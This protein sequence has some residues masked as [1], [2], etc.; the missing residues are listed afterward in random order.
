MACQCLCKSPL[1]HPPECPDPAGKLAC[2]GDVGHD[3]S[4]AKVTREVPSSLY[5]PLYAGRRMAG[6]REGHARV[7]QCPLPFLGG[8]GVVPGSFHEQLPQVRVARL[9]DAASR[10]ALAAGMLG[11]HE[12]KPRGKRA[13]R[14]EAGEDARLNRDGKCRHGL[15][16][17][18]AA[19]RLDPACPSGTTCMLGDPLL[20]CLLLRL[21]VADLRYVEVQGLVRRGLGKLDPPDPLPVRL[22]PRPPALALGRALVPDVSPSDQEM[23][24]AV[25]GAGQVLPDV[26]Q[27]PREAPR[28]LRLLVGHEHLDDVVGE[29]LARQELRVV[30]AVLPPLVSGG[31][32]HLGHRAHDAV[33]AKCPEGPNEV[34]ARDARFVDGLRR[35]EPENPAGELCRRISE[36]LRPDLARRRVERNRGNGTSVNIKANRGNM[37]HREPLSCVWQPGKDCR[38][39]GRDHYQPKDPRSYGRRHEA[40]A[41]N[42]LLISSSRKSSDNPT[43]LPG[44]NV[45][46]VSRSCPQC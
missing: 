10:D 39:F 3:R 38:L 43:F 25:L 2:R 42:V 4:L 13:C 45:C 17:L 19:K 33:D 34:K 21:H 9:G 28:G 29:E 7:V 26:F 16:A 46:P 6:Y 36:P 31:L 18:H 24:Q 44:Q 40:G 37:V 8:A 20:Y 1:A 27:R 35:F 23:R 41:H 32:V 22:R 5:E 14:V 15:D 11:G 12:P 30:S